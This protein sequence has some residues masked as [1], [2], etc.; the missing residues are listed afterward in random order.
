MTCKQIQTGPWGLEKM[1]SPDSSSTMPTH[2]T[3]PEGPNSNYVTSIS[4]CMK[5]CW[6]ARKII[7]CSVNILPQQNDKEKILY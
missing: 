6:K 3:G 2:S 4:Q 1:E 7:Q 5:C